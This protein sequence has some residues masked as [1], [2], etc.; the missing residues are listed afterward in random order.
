VSRAALWLI[1]CVLAY[2]IVSLRLVDL[3]LRTLEQWEGLLNGA[4]EAIIVSFCT[5]TV[6]NGLCR[7]GNYEVAKSGILATFPIPRAG[8]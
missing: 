3:N 5:L 7:T 6:L 8:H 2:S 1:F 4:N